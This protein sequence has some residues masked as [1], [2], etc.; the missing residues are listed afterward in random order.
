M[1]T[2]VIKAML[3][4][5]LLFGSAGAT[6]AMAASSLPDSPLYPVK[7]AMEDARLAVTPNPAQRARLHLAM[8]QER[9][10]EIEQQALN[11]DIPGEATLNR[12]QHHLSYA[13]Q[14]SSQLPADE[15]AGVLTQARQMTQTR[16]EQMTQTQAQIGEPAQ[17]PL[18]HANQLLNQA[19][20]EAKGGLENPLAFRNRHGLGRPEHAPD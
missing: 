19:G 5:G 7:L 6:A 20:G 4:F 10:L 8:A 15:M 9:T 12:L 13:L 1:S 18:R 14:L 3:V 16:T 2:L 17:E 11:G